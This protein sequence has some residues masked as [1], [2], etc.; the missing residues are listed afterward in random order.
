MIVASRFSLVQRLRLSANVLGFSAL[1]A[2]GQMQ[3]A[4]VAGQPV[5]WS[6]RESRLANEYL[7]LLVSQP[8]YGRVV[9]LLWNLYD[10]HG[11]TKLL[12]DNVAAQAQATR[13]PAAL[14][15]QG[16]LLRKSGDL[17]GA[18][19]VY[20]GVLKAEAKNPHALRAR[21]DLA[22]DLADPAT[23]LSLLQRLVDITPDN[24]S[25]KPQLWI[26]VGTLALAA[27]RP[28][29]AAGDWEKAAALNPDNYDLARQVAELLLRAGFPD[30][31]ATFYATLAERSDPQ[32]RLDALFDLARVHEY[33]DQ[34]AQADA[35]LV[36]GLAMLDFRD[37]RYVEFFRRRVRLHE[38]F[39]A[40]DDLRKQLT[41][42][43]AAIPS[44]E[45]ALRDMVRFCE[46]T[47]DLDEQLRWLRTLVKEM[48]Q[49]DEYRW[50]LVRAL[51]D[52]EGPAE[53]AKLLDQQM[54][55]DGTDLP[56]IIFLRCEADLRLGEPAAATARLKKLLNAQGATL[57]VEKQ[58]LAFAQART[59]DAVIEFILRARM[60]RDPSKAETIFELAGFYRARKDSAAADAVLSQ[61]T[62][63]ALNDTERQRRLNDAAAFLASG[64]DLDSAIML[65]RKAMASPTAGREETL[66]LADLLTEHGDLEEAMTLLDQAWHKSLTDEDRIDVDERLF[67]VLIGDKK[68]EIKPRG[69]TAGEFRLPDAFTG[70]GFASNDDASGPP[71]DTLPDAV[72]D[73]AHELINGDASAGPPAG[74][75]LAKDDHEV[76]RALW[77]A[78][79]TDMYEDAYKLLVR[80]RVDPA[81]GQVRDLPLE[82]EKLSLDLALAD[83]NKTLALYTLRRLLQR[84][85]P[86]R[87]RYIMRMS[88]LLMESEQLAA[89]ALQINRW[90]SSGPLPSP[91]QGATEL[92]ERAYRETPDSEPLLSALTQCYS[93]QRRNDD[94]LKLWKEAVQRASGSAAVPLME[95]YAD[96]LLKQNKLPDYVQA[97]ASIIENESDVKRRREVYKRFLD[98]LLWTEQGGELAPS[99]KGERLALVE[100]VLAEQMRRHPF[101]GFYHEA[102]ALVHERNGDQAKAFAEMK[103][104]YYTSPETPFSLGQLRDAALR[105]ADLKAAIYFQ[106]Q[107][108]AVAPPAE[109]AAESRRLV[110]L[111][112]QTFQIAEADRVRRRLESRFSQNAAAL[113]DL[114]EHYKNTGQ[115]EAE[116]RVYEQIAKVRPWDARSQL[117]IALKCRRL[118]DDAAAEKHLRDILT[119]TASQAVS[120]KAANLE[121]FPLPLT[122]T[123]KSGPPGAISEISSILEAAPGLTREEQTRLRAFVSLP[124]PE[125]TELPDT[126]PLV[127][128]RALEE[129]GK[130]LSDTGG[131]P[132]RAWQSHWAQESGLS[133]AERLWAL[134]YSGAGE[135]FRRHL[136]AILGS[137]TDVEGQFCLL[138]LLLRSHG[139]Q[140]GLQWSTQVG[141]DPAVHETR[142]RLLLTIV[143]MLADLDTF[144]Y[145][146]GELAALGAARTLREAPL[147]DMTRK[148]QDQQRY[149]EALELGESLRRNSVALADDYAFFLARI[150]ESAERWD[151]A[152]HYL[153]QVVS[154][155]IMP[156]SYR[157]SYDPYLFSLST[158][159]RLAVSSQQKEETLRHAWK[160]LQRVPDSALTTLRRSAVAGLA[161]ATDQASQAMTGLFQ[162]DFLTSRQVGEVRGTLMPQGSTR[163][164]EPMHLRALWEE[165]REVQA[166]F[167]QQGLGSVV[168]GANERLAAR[169]GGM[170]LSS[171][172]GQEFGEWRLGQ[173]LRRLRQ[174]DYPTRL[175]L[176]HEHLASVDMRLEVSVDT[177]SEL[178]G[179]LETAGMSREAIEVYRL[180]P[181]RA[182]AN[183]E[184]ALW[185]IRVCEASQEIPMGLNF[186][187]QLLNAE[188][189]M[190]PPQPGDEV[191]REKHA[192][193]L[194]LNFDI[195]ELHRRGFLPQVT[196]VLQGRIPYEVPYLRE[197]ALLHERL[198]QD[199][200]ALAAW[201]RLHHAF[202]ENSESGLPPDPEGAMH[203]GRFLNQQGK[204][205]A[206]LAALREVPFTEQSGALGRD[207]LKLRADLVAAAGA[208]DE[209]RQIMGLAVEKK[210]L[211]VIS[212]LTDLLRTKE[213]GAE[214]LNFLTQAERSLKDDSDRFRLRLEL[215]KLLA[216]DPAW[217]PERGRTQV[218]ALFRVRSRDR[219]ALKLLLEWMT[220]QAKGQNSAAWKTLLHAESRAGTD[221]PMA[222]LA[223]CAFA[224]DMPES[225]DDA[226][227][228][229]WKTAREGDRICLELGAEYLLSAGRARWAWQA[230]LA[231]QDVPSLRLDGQ[232]LPLM[233][234]VAH[235]LNDRIAIQELFSEI[236]RM[237]FPG[238][239]RPVE[240]IHAFE[241]AGE[242]GLAQELYQAALTRLETTQSTHPELFAAWTRCMI[243]LQKFEAAETFLM[244][245]NWAMTPESAKL[246]FELYH[247][248]G[249]LGSLKSELPKFHLP[250]GIE[251]EVLFLTSQAM[252]L[253]PPVPAPAVQP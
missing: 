191:L 26:E 132:L 23:A 99:V 69:G 15:V 6:D 106:K 185:L 14:L 66:R 102:L 144:R 63:G 227:L 71:K 160:Q 51:L 56:A 64:S 178:G 226:F 145:A 16:H 136:R 104:A 30:R 92:L 239:N 152:R 60:E 222:T 156:G 209:F 203:R 197:L 113:E 76:F 172:S 5:A 122:D 45:Q 117:R 108:A 61:F 193:F 65:A 37:Q 146:K 176:I 8:E 147:R 188:P 47:V 52:H 9:D 175:R 53:A 21:A 151:V 40:L 49:A 24:D 89:A 230:C 238:G 212:H 224:K 166:S 93:L 82:A 74:A 84:D 183:P 68:S 162:G 199:D 233:V 154:G 211:D 192:H 62:N 80:L 126:V 110:E 207:A 72:L 158:T 174:S 83:G 43:A 67:S 98:R 11:A 124:R 50:E 109:L 228:Q 44:K 167:V 125:Y 100:K 242:D 57:D 70:K 221:R 7:S 116:R 130:L 213:R 171:R 88:E 196:R 31:A 236:A 4:P 141:L 134:Y 177:L 225:A 127:R 2:M 184:Y 77:W 19:L 231:L 190:K 241:D 46:I 12:L 223:L 85:P 25:R 149:A 36:K 128:L 111:L 250:A 112:E 140:D 165:T 170:S 164:E 34:F 217:T 205:T 198:G 129:M 114:A 95:R 251:K 55:G 119:R 200:L 248:W 58:A 153:G 179:R 229:G 54:K 3:A 169:W 42:R 107:I 41:A 28:G 27:N 173:L 194:A 123:R 133:A 246:I 91:L 195:A 187:L 189:P 247:G 10:K 235:A 237:P 29:E 48:P 59:L 243:R 202:V 38:R 101:D 234:R 219:E 115:D 218:A 210:S 121:R 81:T 20:D 32:H 96:L 13:Y 79:R 249:K 139:M 148:L 131:E 208:W 163:Y 204:T 159:S 138:W 1:L 143:T 39:G 33:A 118:A 18:A 155:P 216:H 201:E 253:P 180:L 182:P 78:V 35:A 186:T 22:R 90:R 168:Q 206:A 244:R 252:G 86:N 73:K 87:V 94:A 97:Q 120:A 150:A 181:S 105:V 103:Q 220:G 137:R 75:V 142:R 17:K 215:L 161:G 240:W 135:P 214:A 245:Q 232:K 157:S